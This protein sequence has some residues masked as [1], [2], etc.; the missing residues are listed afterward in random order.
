MEHGH[1][2][3]KDI[4]EA[5]DIK[6]ASATE[7]M[8]TLSASGYINYNKRRAVTMT[9]KGLKI[10]RELHRRHSIL[11]D[12]F[13]MIGCSPDLAEEAACKVEHN[14]DGEIAALIEKHIREHCSNA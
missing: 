5:L 6:M 2:H 1:A 10:A 9:D 14:I 8:Q 11:A 12:F 4:A 7:V 13:K 3:T